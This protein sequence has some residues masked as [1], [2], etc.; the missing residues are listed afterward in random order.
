MI[1]RQ[2]NV[3]KHS[4]ALGNAPAHVLFDRV[5]VT[6]AAGEAGSPAAQ[7]T[8]YSVKIDTAGLDAKGVTVQELI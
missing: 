3:F 7:Y 4:D 8:D 1:L 5:Q 2:E 6:R